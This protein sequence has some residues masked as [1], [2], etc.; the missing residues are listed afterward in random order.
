MQEPEPTR[1]TVLRSAAWAAPVIAI[2]AAAPL[3]AASGLGEVTSAVAVLT[4]PQVIAVSLTL[5]P[6]VR[7]D[8][9]VSNF[10]FPGYPEVVVAGLSITSYEGSMDGDLYTN[11]PVPAG[12]VLLINLDGFAPVTVPIT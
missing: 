8:P 11:G 7:P 12:A 3:V 9:R 5:A 6:A 2:A 10:T 1:R 4:E